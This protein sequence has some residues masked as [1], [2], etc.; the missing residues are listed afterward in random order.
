MHRCL[1]RVY[2]RVH[3]IGS[4]LLHSINLLLFSSK[5][6]ENPTLLYGTSELAMFQT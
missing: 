2:G 6:C 1:S 4:A 3:G 5:L